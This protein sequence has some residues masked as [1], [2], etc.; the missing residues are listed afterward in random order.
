MRYATGITT[1]LKGMMILKIS[2]DYHVIYAVLAIAATFFTLN[3]M[4]VCKE[5][6]NH[7]SHSSL[8][9]RSRD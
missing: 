5:R 2:N 8:R 4:L 6:F 1:E 9:D 3:T 7:C